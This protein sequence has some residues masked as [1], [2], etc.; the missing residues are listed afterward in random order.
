MADQ[1]IVSF[2]WDTG[3]CISSA[4]AYWLSSAYG[5]PGDYG[6]FELGTYLGYRAV[7]IDFTFGTTTN[8]YIFVSLELAAEE[9][10]SLRAL[11]SRPS[12]NPPM[13]SRWFPDPDYW[14]TFDN[15]ADAWEEQVGLLYYQIIDEWTTGFSE[16]PL[17]Q[18]LES[19]GGNVGQARFVMPCLA[20]S[21][22]TT[23]TLQLYAIIEN[24]DPLVTFYLY[25]PVAPVSNLAPPVTDNIAL[26]KIAQALGDIAH[27]NVVVQLNNNGAIAVIDSGEVLTP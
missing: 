10:L 11:L 2:F 15:L 3:Q 13:S 17:A 5:D 27:R 16:E 4:A 19:A 24:E 8:T 20:D 26:G 14:G 23:Y 1:T 25:P 9:Q 18:R 6:P 22:V 12:F 21:E 7:S